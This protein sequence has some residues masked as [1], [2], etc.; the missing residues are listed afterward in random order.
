MLFPRAAHF[1]NPRYRRTITAIMNVKYITSD[2]AN[3]A[4]IAPNWSHPSV[5]SSWRLLILL[6]T[7]ALLAGCS[8]ATSAPAAGSPAISAPQLS[9]NGH[10]LVSY[11]AEEPP[12][13]LNTTHTWLLTAETPDG[14]PVSGATVTVEGGMPAHNHGLPTQP[15]VTEADAPGAYRVEGVRFQ[16]PGEWSMTFNIQSGDLA[17]KV[18]FPFTLP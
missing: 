7:T 2:A 5:K 9:E 6:L 17:D 11:Q 16:M 12:I 1:E 15:Q 14:A 4:S 8:S 18:T 10:F 13:A 3:C